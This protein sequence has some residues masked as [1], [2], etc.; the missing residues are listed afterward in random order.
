MTNGASSNTSRRRERRPVLFRV[1]RAAAL[2]PYGFLMAVGAL[3]YP[4]SGVFGAA[5]AVAGYSF[6]VSLLRRVGDDFPQLPH[7]ALAAAVAG[8]LPAAMAGSSA[9]GA[10]GAL[11]MAGW[12][13]GAL[14]LFVHWIASD[15]PAPPKCGGQQDAADGRGHRMGDEN[16]I[17]EVVTA[18]PTELLF[19]EWRATQRRLK[20]G[21]G[22]TMREV[23][24][25]ELLLGELH[26]RDPVGAARWLREG[27]ADLPDLYIRPDSGLGR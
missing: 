6:V 20:A 26:S 12:A 5:M 21:T 19:D 10:W 3:F 9:T 24:V 7:P 8:S 23:R 15:P 18:M 16:A 25:R 13:L 11:T 2:V 1:V 17:R 4:A 14:A 27:P 22:D